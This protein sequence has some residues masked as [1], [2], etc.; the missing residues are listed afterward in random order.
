MLT[1]PK[2]YSVTQDVFQ[3][4][5]HARWHFIEVDFLKTVSIQIDY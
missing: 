1:L 3:K 2:K 5:K 4:G